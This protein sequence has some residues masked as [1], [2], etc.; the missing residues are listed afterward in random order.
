MAVDRLSNREVFH[1]AESGCAK[2]LQS[3]ST[4]LETTCIGLLSEL[5]AV[6]VTEPLEVADD[7]K[8]GNTLR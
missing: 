1:V 3:S 4:T 2:A 5:C 8:L 6:L 7:G